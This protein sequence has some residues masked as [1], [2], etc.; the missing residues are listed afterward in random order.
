M[1]QFV[2][3]YKSGKEFLENFDYS[4]PHGTLTVPTRKKIPVD[5]EVAVDVRFPALQGHVFL[6]GIVAFIRKGKKYNGL[7]AALVIH[8]MPTAAEPRDYLLAI[9]E[10][11][12]E[13]LM[14]RR[15]PRYPTSLLLRW[16]MGQ[17]LQPEDGLM[18]NVAVGGLCFQTGKDLS[19]GERV[20]FEFT[21]PGS[22]SSL[23][24]EGQVA[25]AALR[26]SEHSPAHMHLGIGVEFLCRDT[27]GRRRLR[28][29]VKRIRESG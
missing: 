7:K 3:R 25:W 13:G 17:L 1:L 11:H 28:T 19:P 4:F 15:H 27:A 23:F 14:R 5:S 26:F 16:R 9:A 21:P 8:L 2:A 29:I 20:V 12:L 6:K 22:V 24:L 10:G 18:E